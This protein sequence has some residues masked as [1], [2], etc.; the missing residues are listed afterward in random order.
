MKF[1]N[2]F[3]M[4][5]DEKI[6]CESVEIDCKA[7]HSS[8]CGACEYKEKCSDIRNCKRFEKID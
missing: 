4:I 8:I 3:I 6:E 5:G 1:A 2:A 7:M